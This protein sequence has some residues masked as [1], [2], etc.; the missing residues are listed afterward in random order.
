MANCFYAIILLLSVWGI[1]VAYAD[2]QRRGKAGLIFLFLML[3]LWP[4]SLL[5]WLFFRAIGKKP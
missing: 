4:V 1:I 3:M 5:S 2:A